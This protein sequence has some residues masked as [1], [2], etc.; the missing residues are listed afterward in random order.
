MFCPNCGQQISDQ[1][2]SCPKCGHPITSGNKEAV[3]QS[4]PESKKKIGFVFILIASI[5]T[6]IDSI[7]WFSLIGDVRLIIGENVANI[8]TGLAIWFLVSSGFGFASYFQLKKNNK[9]AKT[10][11]L[12]ST[13]MTFICI[14]A[15]FEF[16]D[17]LGESILS[18]GLFLTSYIFANKYFKTIN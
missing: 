12:V 3:V 6:L 14:L 11:L 18:F 1:A 15:S 10:F 8:L 2:I 5:Y 9:K 16:D 13:I 7:H 17:L 4:K